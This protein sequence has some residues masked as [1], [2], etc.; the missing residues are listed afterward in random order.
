[1]SRSGKVLWEYGPAVGAGALDHPSLA[2]RLP[3]GLIVVNDDY[4]DRVVVIGPNK[5]RIVW[6][7]GRTDGPGRGKNRLNTPDGMDFLPFRV[8]RRIPAL[9]RLIGGGPG[10]TRSGGGSG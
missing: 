7:Y 8:V 6:Q 4:N 1:M 9:R 5:N 2:L 3:N 10:R